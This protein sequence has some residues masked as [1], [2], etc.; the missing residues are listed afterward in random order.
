MSDQNHF[1]EERIVNAVLSFINAKTWA[2]SKAIVQAHKVDLL[3]PEV[4]QVFEA[5]L[6]QHKDD[7]EATSLLEDHR[8]L[9]LRCQR[10]GIDAA[11][12]DRLQEQSL[13]D[14]P[15][16]LLARLKS[17]H[18]EAEL[19][20]LIE[21]HPELLPVIQQ[22]LNQSQVSQESSTDVSSPDE[23][24]V[25]LREL[26]GLNRL[27]D[28][29]RRVDVCK[30]A[31][32]LVDRNDQPELWSGLQGELGNSLAQNPLGLR[33]ENID[34]AIDHYNQALQVRTRDAF[35]E[36]WA[37]TQN[38][39]ANAYSNRIRGDRAENLDLAIDHCNQALQVYTRDAFPEQWAMILNNLALAY[40]NRIRGERAENIDLAID[41]YNQ[42]LQV[43]TRDAFPEDWALTLNNLAV[44]YS[45][46][47]RGER[48][49]NIDLAIDHYN[50]ETAYVASAPKTLTLRLTT[51]TRH[52]KS[53]HA[54]HSLRTGP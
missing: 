23:L 2:K 49:E 48:A 12:A 47:I 18:S 26:D 42:A 40:S 51:T 34:L 44:A 53:G 28:M 15:P 32:R 39:L 25:L 35:P 16:E 13:S 21:E 31:L 14:I 45:D 43:R 29:S 41:H 22:M 8:S 9:L 38:N 50:Q 24:P 3:T 20:E 54:M 10:E 11:F 5:L 4:F 33:A 36:Q 19:R 17:I 46:R 27:S 1:N 6:M 52:C 7:E 37:M 30:N